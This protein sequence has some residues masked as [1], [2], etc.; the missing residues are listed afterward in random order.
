MIQYIRLIRN[1]NCNLKTKPYFARKKLK[2]CKSNIPE[3]SLQI[4]TVCVNILIL[5]NAH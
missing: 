5:H 1:K 4:S 2:Y 3:E